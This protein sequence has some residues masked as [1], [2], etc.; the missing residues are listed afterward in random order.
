MFEKIG[1]QLLQARQD[2]GLSIDD[3][4][5][6]TKIQKS[7]LTAIEKGTFDKLPSPFYV[8]TYIR[9]YAN[10]LRIEPQYILRDYRKAEQAQRT[11]PEEQKQTMTKLKKQKQLSNIKRTTLSTS[12]TIATAAPNLS[13]THLQKYRQLYQISK[14]THSAIPLYRNDNIQNLGLR[15]TKIIKNIH[16]ANLL[17]K[18]KLKT[19]AI[20]IISLIGVLL[21]ALGLYLYT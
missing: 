20:V 3:V 8:R 6:K 17:S 10:C 4:H 21:L 12:L 14:Q 11:S 16:R 13:I 18:Q 19:T 1:G 7:F 9:S 5:K 2:L 15:N